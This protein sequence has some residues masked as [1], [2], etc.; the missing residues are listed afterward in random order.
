MS[1]LAGLIA[2]GLLSACSTPPRGPLSSGDVAPVRQADPVVREADRLRA[3]TQ[4]LEEGQRLLRDAEALL[5]AGNPAAAIRLLED[6]VQRFPDVPIHDRAL[7]EWASALVFTANATG[8]YR[9]ALVPLDRLLRE[10]PSSA[11]AGDA[12]AL[13]MVIGAY[14]ARTAER[15]RLLNHLKAIDLEFERPVQP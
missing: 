13:R 11:Y 1:P 3:A 10:H 14:M 4:A 6:V 2:L 7:Y 5:S 9:P 8:E 15:D 12:R